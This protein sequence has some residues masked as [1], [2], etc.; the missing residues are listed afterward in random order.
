MAA[1]VVAGISQAAAAGKQPPKS[2]SPGV[3]CDRWMCAD[4]NGVS[5]DL[6]TK[7]LGK[8]AA[9]RLYSQGAFDPTGFTLDNG[10]YCDA[11]DKAC[12]VD[13]FFDVNGKRSAINRQYTKILF[14][15]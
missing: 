11:N 10:V 3:L 13:K 4:A 7:Y 15:K 2:P 14:G 9:D 1:L 5:K 12:Y 8:K 6:T